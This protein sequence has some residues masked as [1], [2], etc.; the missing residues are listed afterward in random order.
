MELTLDITAHELDAL[1]RA[2][3]LGLLRVAPALPFEETERVYL[4]RYERGLLGEMKWI[5]PERIHA[6]CTPEELL[7]GARSILIGACSYL[8]SS[9]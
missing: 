2:V 6:G 7:P 3:G 1:G 4:E 5:T 8:T 9:G